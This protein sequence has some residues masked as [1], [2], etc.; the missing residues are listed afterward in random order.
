MRLED[1]AAL[2]DEAYNDIRGRLTESFIVISHRVTIIKRDGVAKYPNE[3]VM[4]IGALKLRERLLSICNIEKRRRAI[5]REKQREATKKKKSEAYCDR[6]EQA[7]RMGLSIV[8]RASKLILADIH[9]CLANMVAIP[10][11]LRVEMNAS[12]AMMR[13]TDKLR[14]EIGHNPLREHGDV[15][16]TTGNSEGV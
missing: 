11:E 6:D 1:W 2:S 7:K 15:Y 12:V 9:D 10:P 4:L 14:E 5:E 16:E 8:P 3:L 13:H